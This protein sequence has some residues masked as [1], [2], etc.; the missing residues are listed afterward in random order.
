VS[1]NDLL[2]NDTIDAQQ[3]WR[4]MGFQQKIYFLFN[5]SSMTDCTFVVGP[6]GSEEVRVQL[7]KLY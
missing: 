7:N 2:Q 1:K 3:E 4:H 5:N 6:D